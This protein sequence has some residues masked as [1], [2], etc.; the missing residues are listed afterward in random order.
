MQ[1][2]QASP[3]AMR[4]YQLRWRLVR[5]SVGKA[6]ITIKVRSSARHADSTVSDAPR[7]RSRSTRGAVVAVVVRDASALAAGIG[8][9]EH[10]AP[11]NYQAAFGK[12]GL[13]YPAFTRHASRASRADRFGIESRGKGDSR[14]RSGGGND[15]P[16]GPL[17][18][19]GGMGCTLG[20]RLARSMATSLAAMFAARVSAS[21]LSAAGGTAKVGAGA[22]VAATAMGSAGRAADRGRPS[23][24]QCDRTLPRSRT[25]RPA[26]VEGRHGAAAWPPGRLCRVEKLVEGLLVGRPVQCRCSGSA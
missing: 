23:G 19:I 5:Q 18:H 3:A 21:R 26:S 13:V 6:S 20:S 24:S 22:T 8:C 10:G 16:Q 4:R 11:R 7:L 17:V 1:G 25:V 9:T 2:R 14:R 12:S 15:L